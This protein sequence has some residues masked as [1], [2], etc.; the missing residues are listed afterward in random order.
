MLVV[1]IG[2]CA[3]SGCEKPSERPDIVLVVLDTVRDDYTSAATTP[4]YHALAGQGT[5]FSNAWANAPW[6]S[7]G[8]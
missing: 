6:T 2:V 5:R 8:D 7:D 4:A 3:A 1:L